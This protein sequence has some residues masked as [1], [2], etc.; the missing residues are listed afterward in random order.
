MLC[1]PGFIP[2]SSKK[3]GFLPS[4][5]EEWQKQWYAN[6]FTINTKSD[7]LKTHNPNPESLWIST[8]SLSKNPMAKKW[9]SKHTEEK[10]SSSWIP[11]PN[12]GS[13]DSSKN[14]KHSTIPIHMMISW[15]LVSRAINLPIKNQRPMR[16]WRVPARS[17]SVSHFLFLRKLMLMVITHTPSTNTSSQKRAEYSEMRSSGTSRNSSSTAKGMSSSDMPRPPLHSRWSEI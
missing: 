3:N 11:L 4:T 7:I 12:A 2:G 5:R 10:S 15:S 9:H 14:S 16:V 13:H 17:T 1:H 6:E 8:K